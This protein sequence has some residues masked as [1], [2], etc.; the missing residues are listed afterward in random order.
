MPAKLPPCQRLVGTDEAAQVYG[1][2]VSH[3]RGMAGRGEIWSRRI[4]GRVYVYD[5]D[6]LKRLARERDRLRA[7]GK[8]CGRRPRGRHTA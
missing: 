2:T 4:S 3:V 1:C 7:A 6:E 5:A 8:L